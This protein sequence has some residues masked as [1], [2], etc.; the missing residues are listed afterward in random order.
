MLRSGVQS[1]PLTAT[2]I[3]GQNVLPQQFN[4]FSGVNSPASLLKKND[5]RTI[6][7]TFQV[8]LLFYLIKVMQYLFF[9]LSICPKPKFNHLKTSLD[10]EKKTK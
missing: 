9:L 7:S 5:L 10:Y 3:H 4:T 8:P 1:Q 6:C 2:S